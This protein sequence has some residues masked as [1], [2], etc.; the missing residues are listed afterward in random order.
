MAFLSLVSGFIDFSFRFADPAPEPLHLLSPGLSD[1]IFA[2]EH[3]HE[4]LK[5]DLDVGNLL[6]DVL[7][8]LEASV[9][10]A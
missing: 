8:V 4:L 10:L 2:L 1:L 6:R 3:H 7:M 9:P 5:D